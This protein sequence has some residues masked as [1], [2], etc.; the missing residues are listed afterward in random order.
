MFGLTFPT[1][2]PMDGKVPCVTSVF[3]TLAVNTDPVMAPHG[4]VNVT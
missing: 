4:A 1:G 3:P 2:A